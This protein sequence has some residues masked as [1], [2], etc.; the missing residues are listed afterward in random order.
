VAKGRAAPVKEDRLQPQGVPN[1]KNSY[2]VA[3][4][5]ASLLTTGLAMAQAAAPGA[6]APA[7]VAPA[8]GPSI[9]LLDV[10]A[11]FKDHPSYKQEMEALKKDMQEADAK[12]KQ[13]TDA[14]KKL[15]DRLSEFRPGTQD[16][17][18]LE[19]DVTRREIEI[20]ARVRAAQKDFLQRESKIHY[21]IFVEIWQEVNKY[22]MANN[23]TMVLR[24]NS[25]QVDVEKPEDIARLL[26]QPVV[27][28]RGVDITPIIKK[29]IADTHPD[30]TATRVRG[31]VPMG[32]APGPIR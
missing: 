3:A 9:V 31:T 32:A 8:A 4:L 17:R 20:T 28:H 15:K 7:A 30:P 2:L 1:V 19:E 11:V 12:V 5:A 6:V 27:Y 26:Q 24:H 13:D 14:L 10:T 21:N 18:A 22:C 25:D 16:Y 23:V 29:R